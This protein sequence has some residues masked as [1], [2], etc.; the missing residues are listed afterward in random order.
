MANTILSLTGS[1]SHDV[2]VGP[3]F[4][5]DTSILSIGNSSVMVASCDPISLIP[6]IGPE[7]S[8]TLS[9]QEVA[10]DVSTSGVPPKYALINLNLPPQISDRVLGTYW[11]AVHRASLELGLSILGGHTGRFEGC[12]FSI[13]GSATMWAICDRR[14]YLTSSMARDGDD[15]VL[16]KSAGFGAT[17]VLARAFPR[18]VRSVLGASLFERARE[19]FR[20]ANTVTDS[21]TAVTAGIHDRGVTAMHDATEGGVTAALLEMAGASR[22]GASVD[23]ENISVS[24]ETREICRFFRIDPLTT[25][26][27]G[28][29]LIAS[30]PNRTSR[31]MDRLVS[32]GIEAQLVGRLS[33]RLRGVY[34]TTSRGRGKIRYPQGDPYW[35]AYWKAVRRGWR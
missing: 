29:L 8:A 2:L 14:T 31:L 18:T 32:K 4:G 21:L 22:L 10:S 9:I 26:G 30:R 3:Q 19:Y 28:S 33:S 17:S 20:R 7:D 35:K 6:S 5:V 27:E 16:T 23:V 24:E 34:A 13:I 11:R 12:D 1:K 15:L 25:L